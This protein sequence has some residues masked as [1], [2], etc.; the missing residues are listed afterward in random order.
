MCNTAASD[1][2]ELMTELTRRSGTLGEGTRGFTAREDQKKKEK[3]EREGMM[4]HTRP[5][6]LEKKLQE[7]RPKPHALVVRLEGIPTIEWRRRRVAMTEPKV[8][9]VLFK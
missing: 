2:G 7:L 8:R 5:K 6:E 9:P 1:G 3:E 4:G